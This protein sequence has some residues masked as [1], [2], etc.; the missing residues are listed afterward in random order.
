TAPTDRALLARRNMLTA[1]SFRRLPEPSQR[2]TLEAY[3]RRPRLR[4]NAM[5]LPA[6]P[7]YASIFPLFLALFIFAA[8]SLATAADDKTTPKEASSANQNRSADETAGVLPVG[9]N[10]KPLNLDFETGTLSDWTTE[11]DAFKNQPVQ[12]DIPD[13]PMAR[14]G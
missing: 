14:D 9:E 13:G 7:R 2:N 12:G 10:G 4:S 5:P 11:G 1:Q 6:L 3:H 8:V